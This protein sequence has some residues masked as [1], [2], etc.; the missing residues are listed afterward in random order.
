MPNGH[1]TG[2]CS[3]ASAPRPTSRQGCSTRSYPPTS[4]TFARSPAHG[5]SA[6]CTRCTFH[7]TGATQ[8]LRLSTLAAT[9]NLHTLRLRQ[10]HRKKRNTGQSDHGSAQQPGGKPAGWTQQFFVMLLPCGNQ[11]R[12]LSHGVSFAQ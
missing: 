4:T 7:A 10:C 9:T 12:G 8:Q 5:V 6:I 11:K 3:R 1:G 2:H